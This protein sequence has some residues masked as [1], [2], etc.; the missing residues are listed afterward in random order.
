MVEQKKIQDAGLLGKAEIKELF[1]EYMEDY[2]TGGKC[3][4]LLNCLP[5]LFNVIYPH[6]SFKFW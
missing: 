6:G 5:F 2:N 1:R 3:V 4:L